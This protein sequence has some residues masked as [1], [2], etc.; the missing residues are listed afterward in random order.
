MTPNGFTN[1]NMLVIHHLGQ[2]VEISDPPMNYRE[3]LHIVPMT[4]LSV[5]K[6]TPKYVKRWTFN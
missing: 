4:N 1:D 3:M 5:V 2:K 6:T